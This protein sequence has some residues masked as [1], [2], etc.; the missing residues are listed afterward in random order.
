M[1]ILVVA[2]SQA[3]RIPPEKSGGAELAV[4]ALLDGL[5]KAGIRADLAGPLGS[6]NPAGKLIPTGPPAGSWSAEE[7]AFKA[8]APHLADYDIVHSHNHQGWPFLPKVQSKAPYAICHTLH[9][10]STWEYAPQIPKP[11]LITLTN[12]HR[13][14][15]KATL[16]V[17]SKVIPIPVATSM[18]EANLST[19]EDWYLSFGLLA[20]HKG[21]LEAVRLAAELNLNLV[22]AGEAYFVSDQNYVQALKHACEKNGFKFIPS[23]DA[24]EKVR[25]MQQAHAL[26]QTF[27]QPEAWSQLTAEAMMCGTEVYSTKHGGLAEVPAQS[28]EDLCRGSPQ[29]SP[30]EVRRLIYNRHDNVI[31]AAQ[32]VEAYREAIAGGW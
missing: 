6:L 13:E 15:T 19:R 11:G 30:Q 27:Q 3:F 1:R 8:Y 29:R 21:H 10:I 4:F 12:W 16:K 7:S 25:L 9:G 17:D 2:P 20:P 22:V 24:A 14:H 26:I 28:I 32:H 18:Y 31:V 23:P 5:H